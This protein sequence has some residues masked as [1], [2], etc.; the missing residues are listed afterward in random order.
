MRK[1]RLKR[2]IPQK[3][4]IDVLDS[5]I[6]SMFPIEIQDHPTFG[7]IKRVWISQDQVYDVENFPENYTENLSSSRTYIKLK[8]DVMK[9]LLEGLENF[10][11]VLYYEGKE[12]IYEV[13]ALS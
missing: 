6:I 4:E 12:D 8:D 3:I 7:K 10:K 9:N 5:Q 2:F 1:Y 13:R 11:I